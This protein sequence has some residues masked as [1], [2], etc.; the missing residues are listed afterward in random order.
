MN[1]LNFETQSEIKMGVMKK[2]LM[3]RLLTLFCFILCLLSVYYIIQQFRE[4]LVLTDNE[5][6]HKTPKI[7]NEPFQKKMKRIPLISYDHISS[8]DDHKISQLMTDR[9]SLYHLNNSIDII[10]R[11]DEKIQIGNDIISMDELDTAI[12]IR[13]GDVIER[14]LRSSSEPMPPNKNPTP[15]VTNEPNPIHSIL[16]SL[17]QTAQHW[18]GGLDQPSKSSK[19]SVNNNTNSIKS[20]EPTVPS[21]PSYSQSQGLSNSPAIKTDFNQIA[22]PQ[23]NDIV[24]YDIDEYNMN[25]HTKNKPPISQK[26]QEHELQSKKSF[27]K[28]TKTLKG[29]SMNPTYHSNDHGRMTEDLITDALPLR[30]RIYADTSLSID[31]SKSTIYEETISAPMNQSGHSFN[32]EPFAKHVSRFSFLQ[33]KKPQKK[34]IQYLGIRVVT[35]NSTIWDIHFSVLKEYFEQKGI[36]LSSSADEPNEKGFSSGVGKILKFSEK[37]VNIY[38]IKKRRFENDIHTLT[39]KTIIVI[40]NM[41]RIFSLLNQIDYSEVQRIE[42]DGES[43]WIPSS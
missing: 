30:D 13:Q 12:A 10:A 34:E 33:D 43:L 24:E 5:S 21:I 23:M 25:D 2:L 6:S 22:Q 18:F 16:E 15:P 1:P 40:Y 4:Q 19:Q 17:K 14:E 39:P 31:S 8:G 35:P 3:K 32:D 42:F 37:L 36:V 26:S 20:I 41:N 28:I 11:T 38:N 7:P 29:F 27:P 9:K